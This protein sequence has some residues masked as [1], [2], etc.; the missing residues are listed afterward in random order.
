MEYWWWVIA[1]VVV[2][3]TA[4]AAV[5][6]R[7]GQ[8]S[9]GRKELERLKKE[10]HRSR[11]HLEAHFLTR[12]SGSGK[13]RGLKWTDCEFADDVVY[14]RDRKTGELSALVAVT[15]RFEAIEGGGMEEIDFVRAPRDATAVFRVDQGRWT[16]DGRAVMNLNPDETLRHFQ[17]DLEWVSEERKAASLG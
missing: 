8:K 10:F 5:L 16:T 12:A 14:T 15:I 3:A 11:E 4:C 7:A 6:W 1:V 13:P 17:S 2:V 9:R